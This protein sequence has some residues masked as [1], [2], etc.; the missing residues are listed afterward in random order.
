MV[1]KIQTV[2]APRIEWI[3]IHPDGVVGCE[4][5]CGYRARQRCKQRPVRDQRTWGRGASYAQDGR[6]RHRNEHHEYQQSYDR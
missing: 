1:D 2:R 3:G 5:E 4:S 6:L